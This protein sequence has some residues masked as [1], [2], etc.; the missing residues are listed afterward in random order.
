MNI[1]LP[2]PINATLTILRRDPCL[3]SSSPAIERLRG[4]QGD[5]L[6]LSVRKASVYLSRGLLPRV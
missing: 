4:P 5:E 1:H 3:T 2:F 6:R